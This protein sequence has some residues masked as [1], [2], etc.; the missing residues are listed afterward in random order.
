MSHWEQLA[1]DVALLQFPLRAFG[2][3]FRRNV[4]L[5]RLRDGR[6]L[7]HSTAPFGPEDVQAI[8]RFGQPAWMVDVTL[9]HDTFAK[10]GRTA[11]PGLPYLAPA[12]FSKASGLATEPL[13]LAPNE[14][15]GEID[16]I[17]IDGLRFVGE[18]ALFH[19]ASGTLVLGDLLFHFAPETTRGWPRFFVRHLMRLPRMVGI[20]AFF[21]FLIRD[22]ELFAAS[23][24]QL[25][26][27]DFQRIVVGH[28]EPIRHHA[29]AALQEAMRAR[30]LS[31]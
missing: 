2:I 9:M 27:Y 16:L 25:L 26:E 10:A 20:S 14:W 4:T 6:L 17:A 28:R 21:R 22:K 3:D 1:D 5:L 24:Q 11:F 12:G 19:R 7:I 29:K 23:L 30:D 15:A 13:S 18:H 31:G 8:G